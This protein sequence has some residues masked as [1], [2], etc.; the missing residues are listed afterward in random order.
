MLHTSKYPCNDTIHGQMIPD[1]ANENRF[2]RAFRLHRSGI[3]FVGA[4]LYCDAIHTLIHGLEEL[5]FSMRNED[6]SFDVVAVKYTRWNGM[7]NAALG[8]IN[9]PEMEVNRKPMEHTCYRNEEW[10]TPI[11]KPCCSRCRGSLLAALLYNMALAYHLHAMSFEQGSQLL[12]SYMY[13]ASS[14]YGAAEG[15][16]QKYDIPVPPSLGN[17][18]QHIHLVICSSPVLDSSLLGLQAAAS[19]NMRPANFGSMMEQ[20]RHLGATVC[21][22]IQSTRNSNT[23]EADFGTNS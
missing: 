22:M 5:Q 4:G 12:Y 7:K 8:R 23:V 3:R 20:E 10:M 6:V 19:P 17:N 21:S 2:L 18:E 11:L 16:L 14:L 9:H 13:Q 15:I 1:Q